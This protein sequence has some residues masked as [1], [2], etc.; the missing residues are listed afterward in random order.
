[1]SNELWIKSIP[2]RY[3]MPKVRTFAIYRAIRDVTGGPVSQDSAIDV[4]NILDAIRQIVPDPTVRDAKIA[5]YLMSQDYQPSAIAFIC[6][7]CRM[8][9]SLE[10]C[11]A[12]CVADRVPLAELL[13]KA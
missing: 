8:S 13:E 9:G 7:S 4:L 11:N 2:G 5:T 10:G 6:A 1:M 12:L 3:D